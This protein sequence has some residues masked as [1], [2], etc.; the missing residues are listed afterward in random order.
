MPIVS[1]FRMA[2]PGVFAMFLTEG[3]LL[4]KPSLSGTLTCVILVI[5]SGSLA[6]LFP[7]RQA[8]ALQPAVALRS[9]G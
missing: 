5:L 1:L 4:F 8:A 3:H 6:A 9:I 7:A 2:N